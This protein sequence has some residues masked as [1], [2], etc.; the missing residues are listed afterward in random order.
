MASNTKADHGHP[1]DGE[2]RRDFLQLTAAAFG[3]VGAGVF[4]WPLV[5]SLNP[6]V[7][8][9]PRLALRHLRP[10]PQGPGAAEPRGARVR[11]LSDTK[12][13]IGWVS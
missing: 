8:P 6:V 7:L 10:H 2:T 13:K 5:N 3:A 12:I 11:F 9:V 4:A 1:Q